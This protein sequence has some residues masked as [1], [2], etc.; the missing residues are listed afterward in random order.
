MK[1]A[2][3]LLGFAYLARLTRCEGRRRGG[4]GLSADLTAFF[5]VLRNG[6]I[7]ST[8]LRNGVRLAVVSD[9]KGGLLH[10]ERPSFTMPETAFGGGEDRLYD[11]I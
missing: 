9:V 6:L 10:C 8:L 3:H 11:C 7:A 5:D 2:K 1:Y 4:N